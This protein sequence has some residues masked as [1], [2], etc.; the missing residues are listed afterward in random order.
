MFK[1]QRSFTDDECDRIVAAFQDQT[2]RR[3]R[4]VLR[5]SSG[6]VAMERLSD[7]ALANAGPGTHKCVSSNGVEWVWVRIVRMEAL[8]KRP[9]RPRPHDP[10]PAR[11]L[12]RQA[13]EAR[14][15]PVFGASRTH[16]MISRQ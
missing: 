2:P 7:D 16:S 11:A 13:A 5:R 10:N 3:M 6:D 4:Y 8:K 12:R 1:L 9:K 14:Q 15:K